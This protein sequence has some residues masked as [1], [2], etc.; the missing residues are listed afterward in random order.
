MKKA[1]GL[2]L[3]LL[4][5]V[6]GFAVAGN[7]PAGNGTIYDYLNNYGNGYIEINSLNFSG[8]WYYTA[9]GTESANVNL[10]KESGGA[11]WVPDELTFSSSDPSNFGK[12]ETINFSAWDWL[13]NDNLKFTDATDGAP[14]RLLDPFG[15]ANNDYFKLFWLTAD[16]DPLAYLGANSIVLPAWTLIVGWNDNARSGDRDYD[17][18]IVAMKPVPEPATMLL[19]GAGLL[20]LAAY[21]RKRLV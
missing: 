14:S 1:F 6:P 7:L 2:I 3:A 18:I 8:L 13:F 9:V 12:Y 10:V 11:F 16:S 17:D 20:G 5:M 19:L 4:L 21:S 15:A